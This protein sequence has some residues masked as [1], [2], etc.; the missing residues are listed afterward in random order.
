MPLRSFLRCRGYT[1]RRPQRS[2]GQRDRGLWP[3]TG[4]SWRKSYRQNTRRTRWPRPRTGRSLHCNSCNWKLRQPSRCPP[5]KRCRT[6]LRRSNLGSGR[7]CRQCT[8]RRPQPRTGQRDRDLSPRTGPW[9]HSSCPRHSSRSWWLRRWG[10][11]SPRCNLCSWQ[12]RRPRRRRPSGT[13]STTVHPW[14]KC[15]PLH[16]SCTRWP[17]PRHTFP[18]RTP[19]TPRRAL[20]LRNK[21]RRGK[22][23]NLT[24][25]LSF[26]T[27]PRCILCT[28]K[29]RQ[30]S[31]CP[32]RRPSP[33]RRPP[34]NNS[35]RGTK[36]MPF[37]Q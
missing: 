5:R 3:W 20:W 9:S 16:T 23:S 13:R 32:P 6:R 15:A 28:K 29:L 11:R 36:N 10:C 17:P 35:L 25:R 19:L 22:P 12:K 2:I 33:P 4:R 26:G 8:Q 37:A 18:Q 21:S 1:R 30:P 7:R 34:R 27:S 14:P 24:G 31:K